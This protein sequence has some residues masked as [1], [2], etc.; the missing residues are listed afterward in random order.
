MFSY[1]LTSSFTCLVP[2]IRLSTKD[3]EE[4]PPSTWL[5][6]RGFY[7]KPDRSSNSAKNPN[8]I[9]NQSR[10][11]DDHM[12]VCSYPYCVHAYSV[13]IIRSTL[14]KPHQ[15]HTSAWDLLFPFSFFLCGKWNFCQKLNLLPIILSPVNP[16]NSTAR[17][18]LIAFPDIFS[19]SQFSPPPKKSNVGQFERVYVLGDIWA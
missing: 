17:K 12:Y 15:I 18:Q 8:G 19:S 7:T 16:T 4:L 6:T 2:S 3:Y 13:L 9:D 11:R 5:H 14:L 10:F 1:N